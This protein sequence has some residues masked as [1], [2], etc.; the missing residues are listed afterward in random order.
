MMEK[1]IVSKT[2]SPCEPLALLKPE[3]LFAASGQSIPMDAED[4]KLLT[5]TQRARIPNC[6]FWKAGYSCLPIKY[7]CAN[8]R[9]TDPICTWV[10]TGNNRLTLNLLSLLTWLLGSL[11]GGDKTVGSPRTP[12]C[13]SFG[14]LLVHFCMWQVSDCLL[15][16]QD[17]HIHPDRCWQTTPLRPVCNQYLAEFSSPKSGY[18]RCIRDGLTV[19][20]WNTQPLL[21]DMW[22]W[23]KINNIF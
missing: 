20:P 9:K 13:P 17:K 14:C 22:L 4:I 5:R 15:W 6:W 18:C 2:Q 1:N 16:S 12:F 23:K 11:K 3:V 7:C 8:D 19:V 10:W 21:W